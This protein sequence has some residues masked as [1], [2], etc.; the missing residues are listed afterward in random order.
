MDRL[1]ARSPSLKTQVHRP[2]DRA[3]DPGR[4]RPPA[5]RYND[6][7]QPLTTWP[8]PLS[9]SC[10]LF[11]R[12]QP[13]ATPRPRSPRIGAPTMMSAPKVL[14]IEDNAAVRRSI[15]SILRSGGYEPVEAT[16]GVDGFEV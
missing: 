12:P 10:V 15:C 7:N 14:V 11:N 16:D 5:E 3:A 9:D 4:T 6:L 1:R 13:L 2:R 8:C